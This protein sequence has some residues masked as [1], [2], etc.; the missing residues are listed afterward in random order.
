[1]SESSRGWRPHPLIALAGA[2]VAANL[3]VVALDRLAGS[4]E[5]PASSSYATAP[6]GLAAYADLLARSDHPVTRLRA[7]LA[8]Q[9]PPPATTLVLLDPADVTPSEARALESFL[10]GGGRLVLGGRFPNSWLDDILDD[11]PRWTGGGVH[12]AEVITPLPEVAGIS[13]VRAGAEGYWSR[14]GASLPVL[15]RASKSIVN[16]ASDGAGR[17]L[18]LADSSILQNRL[19]ADGDNAAL[20]LRLAGD[21]GRPV[22]FVE[23]VHGYGPATGLDA[24]PAGWRTAGVLGALAAVVLLWAYGRRLGPPEDDAR[25][26]AP[27]RRDYIESLAGALARTKHPAEAVAP[28][29]EDAR[30]CLVPDAAPDG[31]PGEA[32]LRAAAAA[33]SMPE[34]L[35]GGLFRPAISEADVLAV[36]RAHAWLRAAPPTPAPG[37]PRRSP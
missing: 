16:V 20:G 7:P 32:E 17:A 6:H 24:L 31:A 26:L 5:G 10:A 15:G 11:P 35:V 37:A 8:D 30:R 4:T 14:A 21:A 1:M 22:A 27:P 36:G 33:A 12:E 19:L 9:P 13:T 3:V 23:S 18:L 2:V 25:A 34:D 29:Q 28:L